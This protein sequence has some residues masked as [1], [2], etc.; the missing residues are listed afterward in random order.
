MNGIKLLYLL[1][2]YQTSWSSHYIYNKCVLFILMYECSRVRQDCCRQWAGEW[3]WNWLIRICVLRWLY[4]EFWKLKKSNQ[5][6]TWQWWMMFCQAHNNQALWKMHICSYQ[7]FHFQYWIFQLKFT[8]PKKKWMTQSVTAHRKFSYAKEA[9]EHNLITFIQPVA[10]WVTQSDRA[11]PDNN[12]YVTHI[13]SSCPIVCIFVYSIFGE[14]RTAANDTLSLETRRWLIL[15]W[16]RNLVSHSFPLHA[17]HLLLYLATHLN[18]RITDTLNRR[19]HSHL[20]I[21][22]S[23]V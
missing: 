21:T 23:G 12:K 18:D 3:Y 11:P 5:I 15:A 13:F 10:L 2:L 22:N 8:N 4:G 14:C 1:V 19:V 16:F 9:S 6:S 20:F 7:W 17:R